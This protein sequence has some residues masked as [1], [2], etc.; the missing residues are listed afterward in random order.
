[1]NQC[2]KCRVATYCSA[3]CQRTDWATHRV[4]CKRYRKAV[5]VDVAESLPDSRMAGVFSAKHVLPYVLQVR[6]QL[7]IF[8][9]VLRFYIHIVTPANKTHQVVMLLVCKLLVASIARCSA[10]HYEP[11]IPFSTAGSTCV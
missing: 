1:M 11:K 4:F 6:A 8:A 3:A 2:D 10:I 5:V 7:R 9:G